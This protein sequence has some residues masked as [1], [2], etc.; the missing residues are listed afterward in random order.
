MKN[1]KTIHIPEIL[2]PKFHT[3]AEKMRK[4]SVIACDQF[5][6]D[7]D[8]WLSLDKEI[9]DAPSTL[10]LIY[11]EA[12]LSESEP[13][14]RIEKINAEMEEY[15]RRGVFT[16]LDGGFIITERETEFRKEK[17]YGIM[18]AVDLEKYSYAPK[19][20][21]AIR[22]SEATVPER[23]PPRIKIRRNAKIELPHVMLLYNAR[24]EEIFGRFLSNN[25][26][27][28]GDLVYDFD[29][30]AHGGHLRGRY[31][32]GDKAS[33]IADNLYRTAGEMLFAVGDG[34]HSL[35][36]AKKCWD[37]IKETL[38]ENERETHPARFALCEAVSIYSPALVFEP[39]YRFVSGVD[40]EKFI[41]FIRT[42]KTHSSAYEKQ[43]GVFA[44]DANDQVEL[45]RAL[46]GKIAEY[47]KENGGEVDYIHGESALCDLAENGIGFLNGT[48]SKDGFFAEIV[49]NGSLPKK[50]FSMGE[51]REKRYYTEC[52]MIALK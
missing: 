4:W 6:S 37:E 48:V 22:A 17:R 27:I 51:G 2:L 13:E 42:D 25:Q 32:G 41:A 43:N 24:E 35:A 52:K 26:L 14:K 18:L 10:R 21:A 3:D 19:S 31:Y 40:K 44:F 20:D 12:F 1:D 29:L 38:P 47:L 5:T 30:N 50:T 11:P 9:G 39:I 45:I 49:K 16:R 34:N 7:K 15:L 8:Y 28:G 33:E 46:D 36:T 23:L